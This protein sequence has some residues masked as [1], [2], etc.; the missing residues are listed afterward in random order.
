MAPSQ[1]DAPTQS[2]KNPEYPFQC[3]CSDYLQYRGVNYVV[4]VDKYSNWPSMFKVKPGE[5]SKQLINALKAHCE[6]FG[7]PEKL[8][9]DGGPQYTSTE[10]IQFIADWG[11]QSRISSVAYPHSNYRA[12]L[13]VK[14]VKQCWAQWHYRY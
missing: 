14:T 11:I 5:G 1:P 4:I 9:S 12:E 2:L 7:I 6:T 10:M 13:L 3:I 8:S